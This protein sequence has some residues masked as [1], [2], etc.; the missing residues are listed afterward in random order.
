MNERFDFTGN[1]D[2]YN[3]LSQEVEHLS[4]KE[5]L[6]VQKIMKEV[7][8]QYTDEVITFRRAWF[9]N[10]ILPILKDYAEKMCATL[11][12]RENVENLFEATFQSQY[13]FEMETDSKWLVLIMAGATHITIESG[14]NGIVLFMAFDCNTNSGLLLAE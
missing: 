12:I 1:N 10:G 14:E 5:M 11:E 2:A 3:L 8:G 13:G 7:K 9:E 6:M 4:V